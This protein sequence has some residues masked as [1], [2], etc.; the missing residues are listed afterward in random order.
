MKKTLNYLFV[1]M[2]AP[3]EECGDP[4]NPHYVQRIDS[5]AETQWT[6]T[7]AF[8]EANFFKSARIASRIITSV[9]RIKDRIT[10]GW[11][12]EVIRVE[13]EI[14]ESNRPVTEEVP[15]EV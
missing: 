7:R 12:Y 1:R 6:L 15:D 9:K 3:R 14:V 11:L 4:E 8:S 2:W 10:R 13:E 5:G